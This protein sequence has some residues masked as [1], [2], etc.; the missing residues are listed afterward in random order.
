MIEQVRLKKVTS[1]PDPNVHSGNV[2]ST[3]T[4]I[5]STMITFDIAASIP[6]VLLF[7]PMISDANATDISTVNA[8]ATALNGCSITN[9]QYANAAML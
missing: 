7:P 8:T 1:T 6:I 3:T 2:T 4:S 9:I 5:S